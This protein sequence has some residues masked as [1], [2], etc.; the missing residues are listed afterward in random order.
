MQN[1][2]HIIN[3]FGQD[4]EYAKIPMAKA[5]TAN[6]KMLKKNTINIEPIF[7]ITQIQL[8][9]KFLSMINKK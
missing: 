8:Q 5:L 2:T 4:A 3:H 9:K 7:I 1:F 6:G